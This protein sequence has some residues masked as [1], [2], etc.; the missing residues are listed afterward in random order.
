VKYHY[1]WF[2]WS[3]AFLL[4]WTTL[5]V[6]RPDLRR[7]MLQVSLWTSLFGF[8]EPLFVPEYWNPPSLFELARRTGFDIESLIFC[9]AIGGIGMVL[10]NA[11]TGKSSMPVS[12]AY[13][14]LP[15]HRHHQLAIATP[16]IVF[17]VFYLLPWNPIYPAIVAMAAGA[18]ANILCRP[19]LK[20]KTWIG[21]ML[22][23]ILYTIYIGG[24]ELFVP[25]YIAEVWNMGN[26]SGVMIL[27]IPVEE[28]LFAFTFGMYWAGVYEHLSWRQAVAVPSHD[29][30][31]H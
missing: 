30:N 22:F 25:G 14:R 23:L 2:L 11:I 4:P 17:P 21:G 20:Q 13:R 31:S 28:I 3:S 5:Y 27:R 7:E 18:I 6:A 26:L 16:F 12:T 19:D 24:L 29:E 9:F 1:I 15:L 10:Y 8:T